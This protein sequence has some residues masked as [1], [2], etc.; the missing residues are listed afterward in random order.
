MTTTMINYDHANVDDGIEDIDAYKCYKCCTCPAL[1]PI[2]SYVFPHLDLIPSLEIIQR[3]EPSFIRQSRCKNDT[4]M[5]KRFHPQ[6]V[7]IEL[8]SHPEQSPEQK[9]EVPSHLKSHPSH[10]QSK[11]FFL[12]FTNPIYTVTWLNF[13]NT[14]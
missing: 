1:P 14:K 6:K 12:F 5:T 13:K 8:L 4:N 3:A 9:G 10:L 11:L 2:P 7:C